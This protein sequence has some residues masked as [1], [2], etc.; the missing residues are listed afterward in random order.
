MKLKKIISKD[1]LFKIHGWVGIKLSILLFVVCFSGTLA[2]L[3]QEL[4]WLFNPAMRARPEE[5]YASWN[6]IVNNIAIAYPKGKITYWERAQETYMT[7]LIYVTQDGDLKY[8]FVN[9][10]TGAVQGSADVTFQRFFRDLHYYLF[11]PNQIGHFIVLFFGFVILVSLLTGMFY[12]GDWYKKLF[13]LKTGKGSRVF[14]SSL[15]KVVGAWSIPFM[16][17]ISATGIWYFVERADIP[18]VSSYLDEERPSLPQAELSQ[19]DTTASIDYDRC[20]AIAQQAI[21]GLEVKGIQPPTNPRQS[22]Y[23]S[24]T[25][26]VPLVRYRANRVYIHPYTYEVMKVQRAEE[27]N[28]ITWFNDIADPLHFGSWGGLV[29]KLIWFMFG[30]GLSSLVLTGPWLYLKKR[31]KLQKLQKERRAVHG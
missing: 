1:T 14:Y 9:P 13:A 21:P 5:A 16:M 11:I 12:Y 10:Y 20:V 4:D 7:D 30:L 25:S 24:G 22:V 3:S 15:H 17:L 8:T 19:Y 31:I 18:K 27:I 6:E 28:T 23:L 2:T 26:D 29:T